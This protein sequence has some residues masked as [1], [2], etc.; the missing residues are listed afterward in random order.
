MTKSTHILFGVS[1]LLFLLHQVLQK[2][3]AISIPFIDSY[4]DPLLCMPI[5]LYLWQW[6]RRLVWSIQRPLSLSEIIGATIILSMLFE[7]LFPRWHSGFYADGWDVVGYFMGAA[8]YYFASR[9]V[10]EQVM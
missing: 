9:L 4:L 6:D 10:Q 8:G 5:L 7:W 1:L 2:G 3:L